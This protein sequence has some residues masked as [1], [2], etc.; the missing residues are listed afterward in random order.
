MV[1]KAMRLVFNTFSGITMSTAGLMDISTPT[2]MAQ[3]GAKLGTAAGV[4]VVLA[5]VSP[6]LRRS[7]LP[8]SFFRGADLPLAGCFLNVALRIHRHRS[9]RSR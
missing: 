4:A 3:L 5:P 6:A 8:A 9:S 2:E 7:S 1:A